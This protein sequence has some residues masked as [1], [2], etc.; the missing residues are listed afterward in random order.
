MNKIYKIEWEADEQVHVF[1]PKE[2]SNETVDQ[3]TFGSTCLQANIHSRNDNKKIITL[4]KSLAQNLMLPT[5]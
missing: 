5:N 2:L 4:S 1:L 3:V